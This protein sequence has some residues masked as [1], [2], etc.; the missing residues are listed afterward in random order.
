MG[1]AWNENY[2]SMIYYNIYV[3]LQI[4]IPIF[5]NFVRIHQEKKLSEKWNQFFLYFLI[6]SRYFQIKKVLLGNRTWFYLVSV[7]LLFGQNI[8][9]RFF[10]FYK[11]FLRIPIREWKSFFF[12][13][14][15]KNTLHEAANIQ[16]K[17]YEK[18]KNFKRFK[19]KTS[20]SK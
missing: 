1:I 8:V 2:L 12:S 7:S 14:V 6:F 19:R 16:K 18:D 5:Y 15:I 4:A 9:S 10:S 17:I 3:I 11:I 13:I 20:P